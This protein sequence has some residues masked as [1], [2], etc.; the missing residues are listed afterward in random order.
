MKKNAGERKQ[1]VLLAAGMVLVLLIGLGLGVMIGR[2]TSAN[3]NVSEVYT[4]Q[5]PTIEPTAELT[6]EPTA[7]PTTEPTAEPTAEPT[8]EPT[9]EP[10]DEPTAEPTAEPTTELTDEPTVEPTVEPTDEPN[11]PV[12]PVNPMAQNAQENAEEADVIEYRP[13]LHS[14]RIVQAMNAEELPLLGVKIGIDPGHQRKGN[15]AKEPVAPGSSEMKAKVSSGTQGTVTRVAEYVV[16]LDVSLMLRDELEALGAEVYL[17]R[18]T[19]DIDISNVER[20]VMMNELGVDMVLRIHCN[21]SENKNT[22]GISLF[23]K[24]KGAGAEESYAICEALMPAMLEETGARNAG[25]YKRDTYSGMNWSE[26]PSIL[27]EMGFMS[28]PEEDR[29]LNDPAYQ[30]KLVKGMVRGIADYMGRDL[31]DAK[32][33]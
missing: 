9:A 30:A 32:N 15:N 21:G 10:T 2:A 25:I 19:H 23:V 27:V 29:L 18:D 33:K 3:E 24:S 1:I 28:N 8:T 5:L 6:V 17:T 12:V 26:V 14:D 16:N 11:V 4:E 20:A 22:K 31:P 7:E 13:L